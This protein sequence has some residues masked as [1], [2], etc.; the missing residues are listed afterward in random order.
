MTPS[1]RLQ[2]RIFC[3]VSLALVLAF[4]GG[5]R[6]PPQ[7]E[8]L[9]LAVPVLLLGVP[10]GSLDVV[11]ARRLLGVAGIKG[12]A[13]FSLV[14]VGLAALVV[15]LWFALPTL[16]LCAFLGFTVLHFG[17]DPETGVSR[18]ERG[19]YG[20]AVLVLPALWHGAEL[21]RLLGLVSGPASAALVAPVL[22]LIAAPWLVATILACALE[23]KERPVAAMELLALAAVSVTAPPLLAFAVYFCAM[24][25]PRHILRTVA[26]LR[27]E[28][29]RSA[30]A[31]A[32]WPTIAVL[33]LA[34][35]VGTLA[36]GI[37]LETRTMQLVFVG[38][39]ALT[40]PHMALLERARRAD[41]G[42]E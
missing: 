35:S 33:A 12:W 11:L 26:G 42:T 41:L 31:M 25:S 6:L 27:A 15:A 23:A 28:E 38:L 5:A 13:V 3:G 9:A 16:F 22:S 2:G 37:P 7:H 4:L 10:H 8:L 20:G 32:V 19:L 40:L 21:E 14:Y 24:H 18:L 30:L 1:L 36:G 17:G 39:A 29:V 34:Y